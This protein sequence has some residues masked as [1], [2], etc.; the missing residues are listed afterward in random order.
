M[1]PGR[2]REKF[3]SNIMNVRHLFILCGTFLLFMACKDSPKQ[4]SLSPSK[5]SNRQYVIALKSDISVKKEPVDG[6]HVGLVER[7]EMC[8][9]IDS[10][11]GWYKVRLHTGKEGYV[12]SE[13]S[14]V[15]SHDSIPKKVFEAYCPLAEQRTQYGDLSFKLDGNNVFMARS[16][17]S[18]PEDGN[19][20][21][22]VYQGS[23]LYYGKI[24]GNR[25]VFTRSLTRFG[26]D[27]ETV[28]LSEMEETD[29]YIAYYSPAEEG[30]IFEGALFKPLLSEELTP[31]PLSAR[32]G[33]GL[34]DRVSS[35][36]DSEG[37]TIFFDIV[38]NIMTIEKENK[39][40]LI[41]KYNDDRTEYNRSDGGAYAVAYSDHKR[42]E[43]STNESDTEGSVEYLFDE[44]DRIIER[45][46][47]VRMT[48]ITERFTYTG[49]NLLPDSKSVHDYDE[50][51]DYLT[52]DRYEYLEVD[53]HGNWLKRKVIRTY[54]V[55]EY[56]EGG[57]DI[58]K[59]ET[60]PERIETQ[61][62]KYFN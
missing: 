55:T 20:W 48:C 50:T 4:K 26:V 60:E 46:N 35:V 42:S 58:V 32:K 1:A 56:V 44:Q 47:H 34:Y 11:N 6:E 49:T 21:N 7:G 10:V 54:Q 19:L 59:T 15:L 52:T 40:S 3:Y 53:E 18:V 57:E 62:I 25:L 41:Y 14:T 27:L 29:P 37:K 8:E 2:L 61:I 9:L 17:I 13:F 51:G 28:T 30:F 36:T 39:Y 38:G 45:T 22:S 23:T 5:Y 31:H 16:N 12:S 33:L 43:M 24:E